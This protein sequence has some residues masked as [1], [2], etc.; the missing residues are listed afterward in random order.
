M[1]PYQSPNNPDILVI[2]PDPK[3]AEEEQARERKRIAL[4][5]ELSGLTQQLLHIDAHID[6]L[7]TVIGVLTERLNTLFVRLG[8]SRDDPSAPPGA[9]KK[10]PPVHGSSFL[11]R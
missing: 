9:P 5:G 11:S 3:Y 7:K 2:P 4:N 1:K 8:N 10:E 6:E